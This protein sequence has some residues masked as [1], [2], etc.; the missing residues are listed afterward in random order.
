[1]SYPNN[2][3]SAWQMTLMIAVP[4]MLLVGW[5]IAVFIAAREPAVPGIAA[6]AG[7]APRL[8]DATVPVSPAQPDASPDRL[9]A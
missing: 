3:L 4:L 6:T 7:T 1:M 5:V 8:T 9:A 2:I